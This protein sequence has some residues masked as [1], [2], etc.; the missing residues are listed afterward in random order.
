[1]SVPSPEDHPRVQL[2]RVDRRD[3]RWL[4]VASI[5]LSAVVALTVAKPWDGPGLVDAPFPSP[6]R[7]AADATPVASADHDGTPWIAGASSVLSVR[8][9]IDGRSQ[10]VIGPARA[11]WYQADYAAPGRLEE[12]NDPTYINGVAFLPEWP[13]P[14]LESGDAPSAEEVSE[15]RDCLC[16]STVFTPDE[17]F[18]ATPVVADLALGAVHVR[19]R[20]EIIQ[21][22]TPEND[23]TLI[24]EFDDDP[25]GGADWY[26]VNVVAD[27]PTPSSSQT[28]SRSSSPTRRV[29]S[30]R[31]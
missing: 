23:W 12:H 6:S 17:P 7:G 19:G 13:V 14:P 21:Q 10:L 11:Q 29:T 18:F 5:G 20:V 16:T 25:L 1:M 31:G 9:Y 2:S 26:E 28:P 22:P 30:R 3:K 24:V 8:A 27:G 15:L 4:L